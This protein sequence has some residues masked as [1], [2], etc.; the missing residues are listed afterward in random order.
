MRTPIIWIRIDEYFSRQLEVDQTHYWNNESVF[1]RQPTSIFEK[2]MKIIPFF[3]S[4][5]M[6]D[7][8]RKWINVTL[9]DWCDW[10]SALMEPPIIF[11]CSDTHTC[12]EM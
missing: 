10:V 8:R 1:S 4:L 11:N 9:L 2:A 5:V 3:E 7:G 6:Y 12:D